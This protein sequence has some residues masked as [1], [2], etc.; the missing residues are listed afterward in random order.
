MA[1][2]VYKVAD[3][4]D[5]IVVPR[6]NRKINLS[7]VTAMLTNFEPPAEPFPGS[8]WKFDLL[9]GAGPAAR[10]VRFDLPAFLPKSYRQDTPFIHPDAGRVN[11]P[12]LGQVRPPV[13]LAYFRDRLFL[14]ERPPLNELEREEV[15]LRVK[16]ITYE[17]DAELSSLRASVANF[18]AAIEF[19]KTG[20]KRDPIPEDVKLIVWARDGGACVRCGSKQDLHFDHIIPVAKGG[21]NTA[22]NIQILCE[23]CNLKKSDR[24]AVT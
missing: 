9:I 22:A 1:I 11:D 3:I 19:Q 2:R 21:D 8:A 24:V 5:G 12:I 18:E 16:K 17:E 14:P 7:D 10:N 15:I 6:D 13:G 23:P 20:P 4:V